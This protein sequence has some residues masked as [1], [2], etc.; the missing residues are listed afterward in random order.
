MSYTEGVTPLLRRDG[1]AYYTAP[2]VAPTRV[3]GFFR[4]AGRKGTGQA[5][6][7]TLRKAYGYRTLAVARIASYHAFGQLPEPELAQEILLRR[8]IL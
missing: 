5:V 4:S 1:T 7:E 6:K 2:P 3:L 8:L